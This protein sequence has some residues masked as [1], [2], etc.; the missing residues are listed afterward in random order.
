MPVCTTKRIY[1]KEELEAW[2]D[3][4]SCGWK[5]FFTKDEL[6]L[7]GDIH[8]NGEIREIEIRASNFIVNARFDQEECY[9]TVD[10]SGGAFKV[11]GS[12]QDKLL[13][14]SLA[15]AGLLEVE[16]ILSEET[17]GTAGADEGEAKK[18]LTA[19]EKVLLARKTGVKVPDSA[20]E[21]VRPLF[22]DFAINER[23][24]CFSAYWI[25]EDKRIRALKS[26]NYSP[27]CA[28]ASEREKLIG[29]ASAARRAGYKFDGKLGC[30]SLSEIDKAREFV[31]QELDNWSKRFELQLE[32]G[33]DRLRHGAREVEVVVDL[34]GSDEGTFDFCWNMTL[35]ED[36]LTA[37]QAR[38]MILKSEQP[39]MLPRLGIAI[40]SKE[41][42]ELL[43]TWR[44]WLSLYPD[45]KIPRFLLFSLFGEEPIKLEISAELTNWRKSLFLVSNKELRLPSFLRSYQRQ[46]IVWLSNV[47]DKH[48]HGLLADEMGLGKTIQVLGFLSSRKSC[49]LPNLIVCPASVVP[50]WRQEVDRFF[51]NMRVE[52]LKSGNDFFKCKEDILWIASYTQ[53]RMHKYLLETACFGHAILDE[54]QLIKNPDAKVSQACMRIRA[55]HRIV[56][57][58]TP[59]ENRYLDLWTIFRFLMPGLLG[60]R[61]QFEEQIAQEGSVARDRLRKQVA[62]FIL[63]RTK[64]DVLKELPGK[65]EIDY[66]CPLTDIQRAEYSRLTLDGV[67]QLGEDIPK[68]V[69]ERSL[70]FLTLL[71]RLRQVCCDPG[72]LPWMKTDVENSGKINVLIGKLDEILASGH[73]VVIFSQFVSLLERI[74]S[75]IQMNFPGLPLFKLTGKTIDRSKPVDDFQNEPNAAVMLVSLRAGGT[76]ITLHSADYVFLMDPWWNPAVEEQAIDRVHRFGQDRPVFVYRMLTAGTIE[77]RIQQLKSDKRGIFADLLGGMSDVS[78]MKNY[79][80]T[81]S[82]L[83]ELLPDEK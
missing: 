65:T 2:Q 49:G 31:S 46:G 18:E 79:F 3:N 68:A 73:K 59:L 56:L 30:Y 34:E 5:G 35:D 81:L 4:I 63:R 10:W 74:S 54:A 57:S 6:S 52:T 83:I 24:L 8:R 78:N 23:G 70:S 64:K 72:L 50:V 17:Q 28:S 38:T 7:G 55:K 40:L 39:V 44:R 67:R 14:R 41:K 27:E 36:V 25:E 47:C 11:R 75:S 42:L 26:S 53:L 29:L 43:A 33:V 32:I 62:P 51:P 21:K 48:C 19:L 77:T 45:G 15:V 13:V 58:G 66:L 69:R 61:R 22:L 71:T 12:I 20:A 37:E 60:L 1:E 76:G 16:T 82:E 9:T 80:K